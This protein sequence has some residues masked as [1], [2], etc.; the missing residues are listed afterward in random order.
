MDGRA[1]TL[2]VISDTH[3]PERLDRL[4]DGV[5]EALAGVDLILHAGDVGELYVLDQLSAVAPVVAVHGNDDTPGAT[6]AL[7]YL[8]VLSAA[9]HRVLLSH[10]HFLDPIIEAQQRADDNWFTSFARWASLAQDHDATI[11]VYGHSHVASVAHYAGVWLINGG[12]LAAP[13]V[14]LRQ[15][16]RTVARVSLVPGQPPRVVHI[17]VDAPDGPP[18]VPHD[19]YD[20]GFMALF[21]RCTTPIFAP[22]LMAEW[23]WIRD[24]LM[25]I[26]GRDTVHDLLLPL[27]RE[28]WTGA[29]QRITAA[30]AV[31][32]WTAHDLPEDALD[33]LRIHPLFGRFM[34]G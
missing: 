33:A 8:T 7:P 19:D 34:P 18:H 12:A 17:D 31:A 23:G 2:G 9:G 14:R 27:A 20:S 4:P 10:G 1:A 11:M 3:L 26:A 15:S 32:A 5:F 16:T 13:N 25:L 22:D 29:R 28:C 21:E 30:D 24:D 6:H